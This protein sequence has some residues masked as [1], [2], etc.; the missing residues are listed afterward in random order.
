MVSFNG[1]L[2]VVK[3]TWR[4]PYES[5][6][7]IKRQTKPGLVGKHH[8]RPLLW[9]PQCMLQVNRRRQGLKVGGAN[10]GSEKR[11]FG[12]QHI[13]VLDAREC[14]YLLS[15]FI[16]NCVFVCG[17]LCVSGVW[18]NDTIY[19]SG[20][21]VGGS[22]G[23]FTM[24]RKEGAFGVNGHVSVNTAVNSIC[25]FDSFDNSVACLTCLSA[26]Q[27]ARCDV[28]IFRSA[29]EFVARV[30]LGYSFAIVAFNFDCQVAE[31]GDVENFKI[32]IP[33]QSY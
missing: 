9:R 7:R 23:T 33:G 1:V 22:F 13:C 12:F 24:F 4:S 2:L 31:F 18:A 3:G 28:A 14:S 10:G 20:I 27:A 8:T 5:P 16:S 26:L 30:A 19:Y 17:G 15:V 21:I 6:A 29:V 11:N 25:F 32:K